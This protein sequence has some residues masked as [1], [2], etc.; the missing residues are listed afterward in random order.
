MK[1]WLTT[2]GCRR[3]CFITNLQ[4]LYVIMLL[5]TTNMPCHSISQSCIYLS[6]KE[7][8]AVKPSF[9]CCEIHWSGAVICPLVDRTGMHN[10]VLLVN[11][12]PRFWYDTNL[13]SSC[14]VKEYAYL[15]LC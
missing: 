14:T 10:I 1:G 11:N 9:L 15:A 3:G 5:Y 12:H 2:G 7:L 4:I 6:N 13:M 8:Q